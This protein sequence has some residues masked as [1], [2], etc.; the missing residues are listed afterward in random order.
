M[1]SIKSAKDLSSVQ[2]RVIKLVHMLG[3][4]QA[5]YFV[6]H[7]L[8]RTHRITLHLPGI[9]TPLACRPRDSDINVLWSAFFLRDCDFDLPFSH[10][11]II[12]AG[13]NVGYVS[14]FL[15][16]K[17]PTARIVA[18]EVDPDN[19][20]ILRKNVQGY[21]VEVVQGAVW[22]SHCYCCIDRSAQESYAFRVREV[23][24]GTT[25]ALPTLTMTD[26]LERLGTAKADL[27]KLDVEGAEEAL[28]TANYEEWVDRVETLIVEI[29]GAKAY[30]A[31]KSVMTKR[32]FSMRIQGEKLVFSAMKSPK[33][34]SS[35]L[36]VIPRI[37]I[38]TPCYNCAPFLAKTIECVLAQDLDDW[39]MILVDDGSTDETP[40]IIRCYCSSDSRF[41]GV[42]QQNG[43]RAKACNLG[44]AHLSVQS[45]YIFFLDSDDLLVPKA[46]Q[47]MSSYLD[48]YPSVGLVTCQIQEINEKGTPGGSVRRSRWV[49]GR[50]FPRQLP[51][52]DLETPFV[53]F[54]CETGQGPFALFRKSVF[55]RTTGFEEA[56][57]CFSAHEDTDIFCQMALAAK[58]HHLAEPLYLK[59]K[60]GAQVTA[61][62]ARTQAG[63]LVFRKKWDHFR[64]RNIEEEKMLRDAKRYYY[65]IHA[66]LRNLK[67]AC[68]AFIE[69]MRTGNR[70]SFWW[71]FRLVGDAMSGFFGRYQ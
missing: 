70:N 3:T 41:K 71:G 61:N 1:P 48:A 59:R 7:W 15:A 21:N 33:E 9:A 34:T 53:T 40:K 27:L 8:L 2:R 24:K 69:F 32:G 13:A 35:A 38:V 4:F 54:F 46:L 50:F 26:L 18:L 49:P 55:L 20:D 37:S 29:H 28:F 16:N 45:K 62:H 12:D 19:V 47:V 10:P 42:W 39:E 44:V 68:K 56:L 30:E 43:G 17:Y 31:V 25:G 64:A 11:T 36:S 65:R 6:I 58:V 60:H 22:S 5:V 66:P 23:P 51:E 57:S 14:V 63:S 67:V 52:D